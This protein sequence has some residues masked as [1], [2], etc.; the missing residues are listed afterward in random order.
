M[1]NRIGN[2]GHGLPDCTIGICDTTVRSSELGRAHGNIELERLIL[3]DDMKDKVRL[4]I[5]NHS[6]VKQRLDALG[7]SEVITYGRATV[8]LEYGPPGTGKTLLAKA[9]AEYAG[10][11]LISL[12]SKEVY[13]TA[14]GEGFIDEDRRL[15]KLFSYAADTGCI[16]FLDECERFASENSNCYESLLHELEH[17]EAIVIMS[18]NK[19]EA[20]GKA[21]LRRVSLKLQFHTPNEK[22]REKLWKLHI[23]ERIPCAK[24]IN[25]A[26]L[27]IKYVLTGGYIK[28]A[29]LAALHRALYRDEDELV[30]LHEDL[31]YGAQLQTQDMRLNKEI[32][33]TRVPERGLSE[34]DIP[35]KCVSQLYRVVSA[36][37]KYRELSHYCQGKGHITA[38]LKVLLHGEDPRI[39]IPIS[40]SI[41]HEI[42][43]NVRMISLG[44]LIKQLHHAA[45]VMGDIIE[46]AAA[47][48]Q[49]LLI[50]DDMGYFVRKPDD[51]F[52]GY[53]IMKLFGEYEG[54]AILASQ[55]F[56]T[57]AIGLSK[58]HFQ[59]DVAVHPNNA[60]MDRSVAMLM[61]LL[62]DQPISEKQKRRLTKLSPLQ[63]DQFE[64]VARLHVLSYDLPGAAI[65]SIVED[66]LKTV[67][68]SHRSIRVLFG[69]GAASK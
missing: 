41:A 62:G 21:I 6:K 1:E 24:N 45:Y 27:A 63:L 65:E 46:S 16:I 43:L 69:E 8:I 25:F 2:N 34:L 17:T 64:Y 19:P 7:L 11:P 49:V 55:F 57:K 30:L 48:N 36:G 37:R 54:I 40:E 32:S 4:F 59:I 68:E 44:S 29:V 56:N 52:S 23:P 5:R 33:E 9:I 50:V 61:H 20:L 12:S 18:T 58:F 66:A 39:M 47:T 15:G 35:D 28:N 10:Q 26:D 13:S 67:E 51:D 42:G 22:D 60:K 53:I 14:N 38:G 31:E 3:P